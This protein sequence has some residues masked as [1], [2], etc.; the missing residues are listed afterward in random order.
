MTVPRTMDFCYNGEK[1]AVTEP[2]QTNGILF[3]IV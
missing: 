1:G 3:A 2:E